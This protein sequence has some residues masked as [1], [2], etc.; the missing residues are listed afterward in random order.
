MKEKAKSR[1]ISL[2]FLYVSLCI[3]NFFKFIAI[4]LS[5]TQFLTAVKPL[6]SAK[7]ESMRYNKKMK[8]KRC[9]KEDKQIK[10]G[11]TKAGSQVYKCK[12]CG[13]TYTPKQ[14]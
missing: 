11:K 13:K 2:C 4:N 10:A 9:K 7:K 14:K 6:G 1:L 5:L 8:C 3:V 12:H